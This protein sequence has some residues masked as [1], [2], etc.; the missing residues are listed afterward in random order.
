MRFTLVLIFAL[1]LAACNTGFGKF[2]LA[3]SKKKVVQEIEF[4]LRRNGNYVEAT[5]ITRMLFPTKTQTLSYAVG[6][7]QKATNCKD[8]KVIRSDAKITLARLQC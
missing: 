2:R 3:P 8:V 1:L 7:I 6:A 4:D 5:R